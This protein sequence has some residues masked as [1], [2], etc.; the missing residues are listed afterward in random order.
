MKTDIFLNIEQVRRI[1]INNP[2]E[3]IGKKTFSE[4]GDSPNEE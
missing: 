4:Y 1:Q 3:D 2:Q